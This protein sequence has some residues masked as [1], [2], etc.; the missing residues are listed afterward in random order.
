VRDLLQAR[1][2][3]VAVLFLLFLSVPVLCHAQ[4]RSAASATVH[5]TV[6]DPSG[7]AIP[8]A[9]VAVKNLDTDQSQTAQTNGD[10]YYEVRFLQ[11]GR[12]SLRAEAGQFTPQVLSEV[13]LAVGQSATL[14]FTM[15]L[16]EHVEHVE[17]SS[18]VPQVDSTTAQISYV[19][20]DQQIRALPLNGRDYLSLSLIEPGVTDISGASGSSQLS[21]GSGTSTSGGKFAVSGVW[22]REITYLLDGSDISVGAGF[23]PAPIGISGTG[24]GVDAIKEFRLI[25]S[26]YSAQYG[27]KAGGVVEAVTRSGSN[28]LH[29]SVFE[30]LRNSALDAKNYF[31]YATLSIPHFIRNQFGGSLGGALVKERTFF[32]GAY[33]GVRERLGVTESFVS[34]N[35][36]ARSG[37]LPLT[38]G[39]CSSPLIPVGVNPAIAPFLA[40]FPLPNGPDL[41]DGTGQVKTART[42][43]I[44][45]DYAVIRL[46]HKIGGKDALFGRYLFDDGDS[47]NPFG[48]TVVPG[49]PDSV[50][51]RSQYVTVNEMHQFTSSVIN[52][53]Q[54]SFGR[55]NA[56]GESMDSNPGLE[57]SL[58]PGLPMGQILVYGLPAIGHNALTSPIR[59]KNNIL[60]GTDNLSVSHGK[61]FF[62]FGG[63]VRHVQSDVGM[64]VGILG[65]YRFPNLAMFLMGIPFMF[66]GTAPNNADYM[67][68]WRYSDWAAFAQD[69]IRLT[70]HLTLNIGL[71]YEGSSNPTEAKQRA[72]NIINP[73]TDTTFTLDKIIDSPKNL[74]SPR[75]GLAWSPDQKTAVRA[76]YGMYYSMLSPIY[77]IDVGLL[78]PFYGETVSIFPTFLDPTTAFMVVP[79]GFMAPFEYN[80]KQPLVHHYNLTLQRQLSGSTAIQVA[81]AGS[82]GTHLLRNGN[83][84]TP[85]PT[86]LPDGS[87]YFAPGSP[88][89]NMNFPGPINWVVGDSN[90]FYNSLQTRLQR[91]VSHGW[92][93]QASY[94]YSKSIDDA[95]GPFLSDFSTGTGVVQDFWCRSCDR[96]LSAWDARHSFTVNSIYDLPF[97][98]GRRFGASATGA[99]GKLLEGW[100]IGGILSLRSGLPFTPVLG[101][102][103]SGDGS[104][105]LADRPDV[106]GPVRI[107]GRPDQWFDPSSYTVPA[108]G[109]YGNAGRNSITGPK[110]K[111]LDFMLTKESTVSERTH[112]QFR[113]EFFNL[114]NHPNFAPPINTSGF[115]GRGGNGEMIFSDSAGIPVATAGKI[116]STVNTSRQIQLGLKLIF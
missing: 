76:A 70:P 63:D 24:L 67:R 103:N 21:T 56:A 8:S 44:R 77:Y 66:L 47:T 55:Q 7:A 100:G 88:L 10:G 20:E 94:T 87:K 107:L 79:F 108:A 81:Y 61:H 59:E 91:Q 13:V 29:G 27:R 36:N 12:Y 19:I 40:L 109:T 46:D 102:S 53:A 9:T 101:F 112:L 104:L 45:E 115:N 4:G 83:V 48:S 41:C 18:I 74:F 96:A 86:I 68:D 90:S 5:G 114:L 98:K 72:G 16:G 84:N 51:N 43:P 89:R 23:L 6:I 97:G 33:E 54:F 85:I 31:D 22:S 26:D 42:Q 15:Q 113:A 92:Q 39:D 49:F 2:V 82:H 58:I 14:N 71:R 34:P 28:E 37:L 17:V 60:Q 73:V 50:V 64:G 32:F 38:P 62:K 75:I 93:I 69:D 95:S 3:S 80:Y 11:P 57:T 30:F 99:A 35:L 116:F 1:L 25:T 65:Q 78:P 111:N 52:E 110:L 105:F 106:T